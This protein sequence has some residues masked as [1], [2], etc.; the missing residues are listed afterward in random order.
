MGRK[1]VLISRIKPG[2]T[3]AEDVLN[4]GGKLIV[5]KNTVLTEEMIS[6]LKQYSVFAVFVEQSD[7]E[8]ASA[9]NAKTEPADEVTTE[10]LLEDGYLQKVQK[11]QEFISFQENY[12]FTVKNLEGSLRKLV[13]GDEDFGADGLLENA[14]NVLDNTSNPLD[15]LDMLH[16][17]RGYDD[18]T[19]IHSLNVGILSHM[20]AK[21]AI[22][23][24]SDEDLQVITLAGM[25][26]DVGKLM[27]P[28]EYITKRGKLTDEEYQE[29][30]KHT[31]H[32]YNIIKKQKDLD[33]RIAQ[34]ALFHHERCDGTGYPQG[35]SMRKIPKF[36]R[37]VAIADVYDA[38]TCDR[39]YR[40]GVCPFEVIEL[41]EKKELVAY[42]PAFML[43]FLNK[44]V[45]SYLHSKVVLSS[46][47]RG[48][49]IMIN[50]DN[51][52]RP[53]VLLD[54]NKGFKDLSREK[55]LTID[56]VI[57]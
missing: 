55:N 45:T 33:S 38:M 35:V 27:I 31:L 12:T 25:L 5:P 49:V 3:I 37:I 16:C 41:F 26:H 54:D 11:S 8:V 24:I 52:S 18:L 29:V 22:R 28:E 6:K 2:Q 56:K 32:G 34:V 23:N 30:K 51:L 17:M 20:I 10:E 13:A 50:Q 4:D 1:R 57:G 15:L 43:P 47:D 44:V 9:D 40:Q 7:E 14:R 48:E 53:V 42:D 19:F 39:V 46:G 36:A 21:A